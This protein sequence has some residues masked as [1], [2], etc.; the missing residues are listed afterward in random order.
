MQGQHQET[1][2]GSEKSGEFWY[3]GKSL[4]RLDGTNTCNP[5]S[6]GARKLLSLYGMPFLPFLSGILLPGALKALAATLRVSVTPHRAEADS[7]DRV[8]Y[9]FWHGKMVY[10]WL[11][12]QKLFPERDIHAVVSLSKDGEILSR[13][14]EKLDFTLIRGSSSKG[15]SEVKTTMLAKLEQNGIVAIT[16]DG[17]R[18]PR[19][20]FKYGTLR[21]ASEQKIPIIFAA[22]QYS[23]AIQLDSWDKFE[24]PF[25]FSE[26]NVTLHHIEV[27]AMESRQDIELFER[28]LSK[29]LADG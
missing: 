5:K 26:V 7:G 15:S 23:K 4:A 10:G 11:L 18:G 8:I 12:A 29:Q 17:P 19:H 27:P 1:H 2:A 21:L 22:I 3:I 13:T 20:S 9:A 6:S 16:P 28:R 24:I 14:L 25:P